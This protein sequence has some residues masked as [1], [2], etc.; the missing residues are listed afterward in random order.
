LSLVSLLRSN[1]SGYRC[2][3]PV[4]GLACRFQ[5]VLDSSELAPKSTYF[6]KPHVIR[7]LLNL[8]SRTIVGIHQPA[9]SYLNNQKPSVFSTA[10]DDDK[11]PV[12]IE[13]SDI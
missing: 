9:E 5:A 2:F 13:R 4:N 6:T 8:I 7:C 3:F 10:P 11:Q 12:T 1:K